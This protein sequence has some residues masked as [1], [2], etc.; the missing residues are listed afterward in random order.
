MMRTPTKPF[1]PPT[2]AEYLSLNG[3]M[4]QEE[5]GVS[6]TYIVDGHLYFVR[7]RWEDIDM[8]DSRLSTVM[9]HMFSQDNYYLSNTWL[10]NTLAYWENPEPLVD[11]KGHAHAVEGIYALLVFNRNTRMVHL[12]SDDWELTSVEGITYATRTKDE[13]YMVTTD[14]LEKKYPGWETRYDILTSLDTSQRE[15]MEGVFNRVQ[16]RTVPREH[17]DNVT[18]E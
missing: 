16:Y 15:L 12:V 13:E 11:N 1:H 5:N 2:F 3:S 14:E 6:G 4:V 7:Y 17:L 18:F 10:N 9:K 8:L